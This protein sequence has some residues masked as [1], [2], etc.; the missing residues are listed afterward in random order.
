MEPAKVFEQNRSKIHPYKLALWIGC[1]SIVMMFA[2]WTSAY[3]VRQASGNWLEFQLPTTFFWSTGV[4]VL[5]SITVQS[6]YYFFTKANEWLYKGL[7]VT[8]FLLGL[9]FIGLQYQ[10]WLNLAAMGVELTG[11]PSGSFVY[12]ISGTHAAHV[13]GG[14]ATLIVALIHAFF[15][16]FKVTDRRKLR[17]E[18][19]THYWHF[20]GI[21][22]IYL[23]S[24]F[25]TQQ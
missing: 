2:A 6:S 22:W 17:F 7:L 8:T 14:L 11:N 23:L 16:P 3:I 24:F 13:L 25:I 20:M 19:V 21:L 5:S 4:L 1:A 9:L 10:G 12:V 15:L 18:L